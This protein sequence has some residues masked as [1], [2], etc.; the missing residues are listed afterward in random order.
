MLRKILLSMQI[1]S[2]Q[3]DRELYDV[4]DDFVCERVLK[5]VCVSKR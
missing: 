1:L 3:T 4:A 2:A 5:T